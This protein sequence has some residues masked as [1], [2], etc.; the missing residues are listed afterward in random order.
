MTE[1]EIAREVVDAA[2]TVHRTFGPGLLSRSTRRA[3]HSSFGSA[4][5]AFSARS[6]CR[7]GTAT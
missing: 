7:F 3:S 5:F 4:G 6:R 1:N 2:L